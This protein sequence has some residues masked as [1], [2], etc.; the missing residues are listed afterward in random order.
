M[1]YIVDAYRHKP[2]VGAPCLDD[3]F[4]ETLQWSHNQRHGVSNHLQLNSSFNR[5]LRLAPK[6]TSKA[7][8]PAFCEGDPPVADGFPLQR[9]SNAENFSMSWRRP[10]HDNAFTLVLIKIVQDV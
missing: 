3:F 10:E 9:A 4:F 5:M 2:S 6:K 8:I 7:A 1:V